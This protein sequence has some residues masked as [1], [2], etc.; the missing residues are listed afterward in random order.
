MNE[1]RFLTASQVA[2]LFEVSPSTVVRWAKDGKLPFLT[3]PGGRRRFP[4]EAVE[5]LLKL[6]EGVVSSKGGTP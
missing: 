3:T 5:N 2:A 1:R 4:R 6:S